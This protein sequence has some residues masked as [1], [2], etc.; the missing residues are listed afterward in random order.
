MQQPAFLRFAY[1]QI[2]F[3]PR[4]F[5]Y[6]LSPAFAYNTP[7]LGVEDAGRLKVWRQPFRL[8]FTK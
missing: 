7:Y 3:V 2:I 4:R 1:A 6:G 5:E 8:V